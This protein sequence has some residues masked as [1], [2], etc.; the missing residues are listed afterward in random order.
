MNWMSRG[1]FVLAGLA[2]AGLAGLPAPS[3]RAAEAVLPSFESVRAAY[4]PSD[5]LVTD[6]NDIVLQRVRREPRVRRL[7]WA[8]LVALAPTLEAALLAAEDKRFHEHA[9]VDWLAAARAA[10]DKV[11]AQSAATGGRGASTLTMQ[12][13][14]LLDPAL[15]PAPRQRR[16]VAQ[17]WDQAAA[18]MQL[19]RRW[20][21]AQILEAYVN[22]VPLRG[23]TVGIAAASEFWFG[24]APDGVDLAEAA[25]L[26]A[27]IRQPQAKPARVG[28]RA[29]AIVA[30]LPVSALP[31]ILRPDCASIKARART[32][33]FAPDAGRWREPLAP[34]LARRALAERDAAADPVMPTALPATPASGYGQ[35]H[36]GGREPRLRTTLDAR[37]QSFAQGRL[38]QHLR[39]LA[40]RNVED[41]ALVV[42]D[43]A[44][45]EVLA[46][47]GSSGELSDA[48]QVDGVTALRQA[49]STLKP[50]LYGLAIERRLLTAASLVDDSPLALTAEN[51]AYIP[52]NYDRRFQGMVSVRTA[53]ASSLNIP[54]V[55]TLLLTGPDDF[56]ALLRRAGFV[57]LTEPADY[58]GLALALGGAEVRLLDLANAYRALAN[59]GRW[60]PVA[61]LVLP[62]AGGA[63]PA[64][65][66]RR[67]FS[68]ATAWIL[69]DILSDRGARAPTFGLENALATRV[70][71]AVKT[72]TS[73]DMRDNWAVGY[74]AR[75]TVAVW[76]GNFSGMPMWNVSGVHGAA[77]LWRDIVHF[78][79]EHAPGAQPSAPPGIEAVHVE[80]ADIAEASRRE[81]FLPGTATPR[82]TLA[83][84]RGAWA[85]PSSGDAHPPGILYPADGLIVALDPDIPAS[86][87]RIP[88]RMTTERSGY[89][90]S[91]ERQSGREG[92]CLQTIAVPLGGAPAE[93][94]PAP[95][96]W[97][98]TLRV[99]TTREA[100]AETHI[101]VR[102]GERRAVVCDGLSD[103]ARAL[104]AE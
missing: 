21:K 103:D 3:A 64:G 14:A 26:A 98:V 96:D 36:G 56:H 29:C 31:G 30:A 85:E 104:A 27:L 81:W 78:L 57:T 72:G 45:G 49:G 100:V 90:W 88:L 1:R 41:S 69:G 44:S 97:R 95:G 24:K 38:T 37:L 12:L 18:A 15:R 32:S 9:G 55:R 82:V 28:E 58:Y 86:I 11:A 4:R 66:G 52:Q 65:Q 93:W 83:D 59:G 5:W 46:W 84:R 33:L 8:P 99:S 19:E 23:E 47:V 67:L 61:P 75:Y 94:A 62:P 63:A 22:L 7:G 76:V 2:C 54:A 79:H 25:L 74:T 50:F 6:R 77:P 92:R 13:A 48:A 53:L 70:W 16:D 101:H 102:G 34:H 68:P 60:S 20:S 35:G 71:S 10:L 39:E 17:K 73:K 40:G 43:N 89:F 80:F 87:E 91:L 42:L 51:G